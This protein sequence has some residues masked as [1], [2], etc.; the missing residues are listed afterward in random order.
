[1][2]GEAFLRPADE[3]TTRLCFVDF[4]GKETLKALGVLMAEKGVDDP[5]KVDLDE[6]FLRRYAK[7]V[8][9]AMDRIKRF[10]NKYKE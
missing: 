5:A 3:F 7:N 6:E 1:M 9:V 4:N 2:G 10:V 8:V